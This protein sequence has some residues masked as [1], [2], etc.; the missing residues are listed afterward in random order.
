M[1]HF[2]SLEPWTPGILE[3]SIW[4]NSFEDDP[5][6]NN[7]LSKTPILWYVPNKTLG[8]NGQYKF[9]NGYGQSPFFIGM[10]K[11]Q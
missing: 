2:V 11:T 9:N 7:N 1:P 6:F 5:Y 4:I 8:A 3:S 10:E